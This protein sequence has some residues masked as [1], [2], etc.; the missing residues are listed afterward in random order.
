MNDD[1]SKE[2]DEMFSRLSFAKGSIHMFNN[3]CKHIANEGTDAYNMT[4][5]MAIE[6]QKVCS[7]L[8]GMIETLQDFTQIMDKYCKIINNDMQWIYERSSYANRRLDEHIARSKV[9]FAIIGGND[10][11]N[12]SGQQNQSL[13]LDGTETEV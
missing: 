8:C 11:S 10:E 1:I 9:T 6:L 13:A 3:F 5:D 4:H 7:S 12:I 2:L